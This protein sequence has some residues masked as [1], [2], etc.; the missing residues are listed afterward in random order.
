MLGLIYP[1]VLGTILYQLFFTIAH[2]L[3]EQYPLSAIVWIKW[4]LVV[5]SIGFYVCDYLYI[6]FTKGY[7]WWSFVCDIVFLLAFYATVISIDVDNPRSLPHNK[8][9]LFCYF[10][11][12][13]VY[14]VWDGHEFLTLPRGK[15]RDF[16]RA[17]VFWEL[18]WLVVI[19]V[20]EIIALAWNNHLMISIL[21]IVILSI[22]TIWFGFLVSRMRKFS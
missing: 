3:R 18:P 13:L 5:I 15:E 16:Y 4:T 21:T 20:F 1:A 7:Y 22:V 14:L 6:V 11:F 8:V 10:I 12:L 2:V 19:G 9:I 17:V